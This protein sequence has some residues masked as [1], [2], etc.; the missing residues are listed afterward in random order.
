MSET[1]IPKIRAG[2]DLV[3]NTKQIPFSFLDTDPNMTARSD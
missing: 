3:D 2:L 1:I